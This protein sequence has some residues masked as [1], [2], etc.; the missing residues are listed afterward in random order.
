MNHRLLALPL[1]FTVLGALAYGAGCA[2][3][4]TSDD[5]VGRSDDIIGG[6]PITAKEFDA[7]G[8]L[9][10]VERTWGTPDAPPVS[11]FPFCTGT[12][13]EQSTILTAQHC[14]EW[15][16]KRTLLESSYFGFDVA[17]AI[18]PDARNPKRLIPIVEAQ[19]EQSI[20]GGVIGMGS[21]V[22]VLH[23]AGAVK[24]VTPIPFAP[25]PY[26]HEGRMTIMGYGMQNQTFA[27]GTRHAASTTV[28]ATA[29]KVYQLMYGSFDQFK[30]Q[31][32]QDWSSLADPRLTVVDPN[33]PEANAMFQKIYDETTLVDGYEALIGVSPG[34]GT[35]C[36]G[37]S[38]GPLLYK[39]PEGIRVVGVT[40]WGGMSE[41][42]MCN[43]EDV[44]AIVGPASAEFI[45]AQL[46]RK[47]HPCDAIPYE[48]QCDGDTI[49]RCTD[50]TNLGERRVVRN[51]CGLLGDNFKCMI[52]PPPEETPEAPAG[53]AGG[54]PTRRQ[55]DTADP[56]KGSIIVPSEVIAPSP[57]CMIPTPDGGTDASTSNDT[58]DGG[59]R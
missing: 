1:C 24:D 33:S 43:R 55:R 46:A 36:F 20:G 3:P 26:G 19:V 52:P 41:Y 2:D 21:D 44:S 27:F 13:I 22:A 50:Y 23:L 16:T 56:P 6:A 40:S 12:L 34:D 30:A 15:L 47:T 39:G 31:F 18:G 32:L 4:S 28:K 9:V 38:G 54:G 42:G 58:A 51:D 49:V 37:D 17:F 10:F 29:G 7:V 25:F 14:S 59:T 53:N 5:G 57:V 11:I 48:G 35:T 45:R 8:S